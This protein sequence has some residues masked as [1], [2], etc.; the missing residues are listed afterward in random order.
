MADSQVVVPA[1]GQ[2]I[3]MEDG[4][5]QV[6][7]QPVIAFVEG[8]GVGRDIWRAARAV[9]EAAVDKAYA[10]KRKIHWMEVFAGE[11]A[12][13]RYNTWLP[14]ETL[15]AFSEFRVGMRGPLTSPAGEGLRSFDTVLC[16][17][18]D[19]YVYQRPVRYF[20]G[21]PSPLVNPEYVDMVVFRE[22]TEDFATG[23]EFQYGTP[24]NQKF[25][26]L[27][28][29][30]FPKQYAKI[31][32]P[33]TAAIGIKP[34]SAQGTQRLVRAAIQWALTNQRRSINLVHKG[35]IMK[36][37]EGSFKD[38]G[39]AL[40]TAEFRS[41]IVT[42]RESWILGN[43]ENNP[44]LSVEEN[45]RLIDPGFEMMSPDQQASIMK[46]V[47]A[48]LT[49]WATHGNGKWKSKLLIKDS[50]A[51]VTLQFILIRPRDYDVIATMNLNGDFIL[52]AL[53]AEVG[54]TGI[55]PGANLNYAT[56]N[57]V[58]NA[59]HGAMPDI[60]DLDIANPG[61]LILSGEMML[62]YLGWSEAADLIMKGMQGTI[63]AKTLTHD[64]AP[65]VEGAREVGCSEFGEAVIN[66]M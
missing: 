17:A 20:E 41:E 37:T 2:K 8:D 27:F 51:D 13:K 9:F 22:N 60:A 12:L 46:E 47:E 35:N 19:L 26:D 36:Y 63:K 15:T 43:R 58:F 6:P 14:G 64:L 31:R 59:T 30:L 21:L 52:D 28:K 39:Y 48:A 33:E 24:Q 7:D 5:L 45:A 29:Q 66:N 3:G 56:G 40:A 32:F 38:W 16:Q 54:G 1:N 42:E 4:R 25:K 53:S 62:R 11:K 10:G 65:Q 44:H 34:V 49:L 57:A 55:A 23:I 50:I 61:S 18:L